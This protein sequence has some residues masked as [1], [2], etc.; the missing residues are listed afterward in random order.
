MLLRYDLNIVLQDEAGTYHLDVDG[1]AL[2]VRGC[3][4]TTCVVRCRARLIFRVAQVKHPIGDINLLDGCV[5]HS[6]V[7]ALGKHIF[8]AL[9]V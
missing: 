4:G 5:D 6:F 7:A 3:A 9:V 1:H 2:P 8:D